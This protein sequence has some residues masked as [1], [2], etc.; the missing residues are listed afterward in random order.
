MAGVVAAGVRV[1][2][3]HVGAGAAAREESAYE[4]KGK[5]VGSHGRRASMGGKVR[6]G[7]GVAPSHSGD[8]VG[9]GVR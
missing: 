1:V 7:R 9:R 4:G 3:R 5:K 6:A 2:E 8:G